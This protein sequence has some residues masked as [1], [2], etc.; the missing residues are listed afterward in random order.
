MINFLKI[1]CLGI[2][3]LAVL[4]LLW[5][6]PWNAGPI[7]QTLAL[8]ILAVHVVEALFAF[9][10]IKSYSGPLWMSVVLAVLFGMLHWLPLVKKK[11]MAPES[12]PQ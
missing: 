12:A 7:L 10:H 9:R 8:A 6:L 4:S 1:N 5:A 2:Y 3:G 11:Q